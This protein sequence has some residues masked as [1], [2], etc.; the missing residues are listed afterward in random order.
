MLGIL[1]VVAIGLLLYGRPW[2]LRNIK[3]KIQYIPQKMGWNSTH[4]N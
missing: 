4:D 1:A 3:E 2:I